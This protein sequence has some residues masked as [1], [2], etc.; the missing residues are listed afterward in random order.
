MQWVYRGILQI[1]PAPLGS[2]LKKALFIKRKTIPASGM[3]F[4]ADPASHFGF[5]LLT[6]GQYEPQ[7]TE[8][9]RRI[10]RSGDRFVD[11]GG[12]EGYF[13]VLASRLVGSKGK[14]TCV[15]P[16]SRL[17]DVIKKNLEINKC[18]NVDLQ[19]VAVCN[20]DEPVTLHLSSDNNTGGTSFYRHWRVGSGSEIVPAKHL[21]DM[22]PRS[23]ARS[24]RLLKIDCEGAESEIIPSAQRLLE[25]Q[26]FQFIS[27][28]YHPQLI[29]ESGVAVI[30]HCLRDAGYEL[31]R[32]ALGC[33]IYHLP[34]LRQEL[35]AWGPVR[36]IERFKSVGL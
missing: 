32:T 26:V 33:W 30:D 12:N 27:I 13:T 31:V 16:Q 19:R 15:E 5:E 28:E 20:S 1:R 24:I 34:D 3:Q 8:V 23:D 29:G 36:S 4:W 2:A 22:F 9:L 14:V 18:R 21:D 35:E 17:Q 7:L 10:L 11:L 25:K 6:T